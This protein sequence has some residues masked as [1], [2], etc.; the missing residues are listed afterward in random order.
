VVP[1]GGVGGSCQ[2]HADAAVVQAVQTVRAVAELPRARRVHGGRAAVYVPSLR[3]FRKEDSILDSCFSLVSDPQVAGSH[4]YDRV[5]ARTVGFRSIAGV[6]AVQSLLKS[7]QYV[8]LALGKFGARNAG[9]GSAANG[10]RFYRTQ[11]SGWMASAKACW[12]LRCIPP[13]KG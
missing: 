6:A 3:D 7:I 11:L 12:V 10:G 13:G 4:I 2:V 8:R 1:R 5:V 9:T